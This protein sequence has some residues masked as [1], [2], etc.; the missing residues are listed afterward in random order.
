MIKLWQNTCG[1]AKVFL[2][3]ERYKKFLTAIGKYEQ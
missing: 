3:E 2:P 1:N